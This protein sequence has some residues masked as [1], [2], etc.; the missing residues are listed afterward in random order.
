MMGAGDN[1]G[2]DRGGFDR[3]SSSGSVGGP[4]SSSNNKKEQGNVMYLCLCLLIVFICCFP[5][6]AL[7][8]L[9]NEIEVVHIHMCVDV[10][11]NA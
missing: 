3:R 10:C 1:R 4:L 7:W 5:C 6:F 8:M 9:E 11:T 2:M